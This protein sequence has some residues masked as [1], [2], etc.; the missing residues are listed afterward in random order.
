M[1]SQ[2][3]ERGLE[4]LA[5]AGGEVGHGDDLIVAVAEPDDAA[6]DDGQADVLKHEGIEAELD[7]VEG[8]VFLDEVGEGREQHASALAVVVVL[9]AG[10]GFVVEDNEACGLTIASVGI[11]E[12]VEG[13]GDLLADVLFGAWI[14]AAVRSCFVEDEV[15]GGRHLVEETKYSFFLRM[16]GRKEPVLGHIL[17]KDGGADAFGHS[18]TEIAEALAVGMSLGAEGSSTEGVLPPLLNP[19]LGGLAVSFCITCRLPLFVKRL[20]DESVGNIRDGGQRLALQ[21]VAMSFVEELEVGECFENELASLSN[22]RRLARKREHFVH[23]HSF[24]GLCPA[25]L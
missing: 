1:T 23:I 19:V 18:G 11:I 9:E 3:T 10:V 8:K 4:G 16:D 5:E 13:A 20:A 24:A 14:L 21:Q 15:H 22:Y 25:A 6:G 12:H 17:R 2:H 7:G